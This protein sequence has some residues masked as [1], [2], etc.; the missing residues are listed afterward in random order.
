MKKLHAPAGLFASDDPAARQRAQI[1]ERLRN[2]EEV[3][4]APSGELETAD[5][6]DDTLKLKAPKG[7][8][9]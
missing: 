3:V 9:A 5:P 7:E 2:N 8:L 4:I 1:A 6:S